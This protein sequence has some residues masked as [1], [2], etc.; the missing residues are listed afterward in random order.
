[1]SRKTIVIRTGFFPLPSET[2]ITNH[3]VSV[4]RMGYD[5][6]LLVDRK[7]TIENTTQKDLIEE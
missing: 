6:K 5:V 2:F 1:M 3:V 4:I 7:G